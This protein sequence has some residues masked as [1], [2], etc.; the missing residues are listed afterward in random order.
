MIQLHGNLRS[1]GRDCQD[2]TGECGAQTTWTGFKRLR[3]GAA[4]TE[5]ISLITIPRV[6]AS[7]YTVISYAS[8]G[9]RF[10]V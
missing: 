5:K 9:E 8:T 2:E 7:H 4:A 6:I 3:S 10:P 1:R